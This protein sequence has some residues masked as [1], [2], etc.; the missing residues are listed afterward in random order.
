MQDRCGVRR[1]NWSNYENGNTEPDIQTLAQIA[2]GFNVTIDDLVLRNFEFDVKNG[3][4][5]PE[6]IVLKSEENGKVNSNLKGNL[7]NKKEAY[8]KPADASETQANEVDE[9]SAWAI[10]GQLKGVHEKLDQLRVL[11]EKNA[12]N[13][14]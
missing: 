5:N 3:N 13:N 6:D 1:A 11:A 9:V 8:Y 10:M 2:S 14:P 12:K 4:L 7:T